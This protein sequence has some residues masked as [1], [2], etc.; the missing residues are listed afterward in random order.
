MSLKTF[1]PVTPSRALLSALKV[2]AWGQPTQSWGGRP[3]RGSP[4]AG[5][6][7]SGSRPRARRTMSGVSSP[8]AGRGPLS[9]AQDGLAGDAEQP[10]ELPLDERIAVLEDED[11]SDV[12]DELPDELFGQRIGR[13]LEEGRRGGVRGDGFPEIVIGDARGDDTEGA[14]LFVELQDV[15]AGLLREPGH[16]GLEV[17]EPAEPPPGVDGQEDPVLA[18]PLLELVLGPGVPRLHGRTAVG[19]ARDQAH[20]DGQAEALGHVVGLPGH[21]IGLLVVGRL[22]TG[23]LGELDVVAAVLLVLRAV[24]AGVVGAD[25]EEAAVGPGDGRVHEGVGGDV[26]ADMLEGDEGPLPG[27]RGAE[28]LFVCGLL[29]HRPDGGEGL[30]LRGLP[31]QVFQDLGRRRPGIGIGGRQAGVDGPQGDRFVT[32]QDLTG[33]GRSFIVGMSRA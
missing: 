9:L 3:A 10:L 33:H 16:L 28:G 15:E 11:R 19:E 27:E 2:S 30:G 26:E 21:V 13:D 20:E 29:V 17:E 4:L 25:D 6:E 14:V 18:R 1:A 22:V 32:E 8:E 12:A 23:D 24:H 7:A 5:R 31:H